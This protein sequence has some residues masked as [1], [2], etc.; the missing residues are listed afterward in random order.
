MK[1]DSDSGSIEH[2]TLDTTMARENIWVLKVPDFVAE[3][4]ANKVEKSSTAGGT[5]SSVTRL[6]KVSVEGDLDLCRFQVIC[7]DMPEEIPSKYKVRRTGC[8][9]YMVN[10]TVKLTS[11]D[12]LFCTSTDAKKCC[13]GWCRSWQEHDAGDVG[14]RW[15]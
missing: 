8:T 14:A 1:T 7:D 3:Q 15:K 13:C 11:K 9:L 5:S 4:W 12:S 2:D 10:A 6:G